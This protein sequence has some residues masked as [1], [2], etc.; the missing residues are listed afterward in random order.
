MN[1]AKD[2]TTWKPQTQKKWD[3]KKWIKLWS[4]KFETWL[5]GKAG[6]L[7]PEDSSLPVTMSSELRQGTGEGEKNIGHLRRHLFLFFYSYS[8]LNLLDTKKVPDI[9]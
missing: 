1:K 6:L 9:L 8:F 5:G 4:S 3:T 7:T 2:I